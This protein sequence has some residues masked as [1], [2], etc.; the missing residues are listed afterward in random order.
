MKRYQFLTNA[1]YKGQVYD[2][3]SIHEL[4]DE[5]AANMA[6]EIREVGGTITEIEPI[7]IEEIPAPEEEKAVESAPNKMQKK[8]K[9]K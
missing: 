8:R 5:D 1:G 9:K 2:A 7:H 3:G 6:S 4:S